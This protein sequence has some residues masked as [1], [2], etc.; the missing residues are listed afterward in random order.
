MADHPIL[1]SQTATG[2]VGCNPDAERVRRNDTV[3]W[4]SSDY[5][6]WLVVFGPGAPVSPRVLRPTQPSGTILAKR[7]ADFHRHK[8]VVVAHKDSTLEF[9]DPELIV[10][11]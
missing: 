1:I 8:Y 2:G 10:E 11:E 9:D 3:T 4:S 7:A 5:T 6:Q